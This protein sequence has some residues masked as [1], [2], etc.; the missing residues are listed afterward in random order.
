MEKCVPRNKTRR[1][2]FFRDCGTGISLSGCPQRLRRQ[3]PQSYRVKVGSRQ[4]T[5][6]RH[7][8]YPLARNH[9]TET[10]IP[11]QHP[12]Q[13]WLTLRDGD[14]ST[15]CLFMGPDLLACPGGVYRKVPSVPLGGALTW[16]TTQGAIPQH[17]GLWRCTHCSAA[18]SSWL[19]K[20]WVRSRNLSQ[21]FC[22]L[23]GRGL[24]SNQAY[25]GPAQWSALAGTSWLQEQKKRL[26]HHFPH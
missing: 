19:R 8:L 24:Q 2:N 6:Q 25:S 13:V 21:Q 22:H 16:H 20:A 14:Y 4:P 3:R 9:V 17:T 11:V 10:G 26:H 23:P 15:P 7:G 12:Y 5:V 1:T 18:P